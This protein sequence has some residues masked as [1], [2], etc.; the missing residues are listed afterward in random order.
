MGGEGHKERVNEG[1]Y[2]GCTLYSCMKTV[3]WNL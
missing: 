3:Q 1:Q 2:G